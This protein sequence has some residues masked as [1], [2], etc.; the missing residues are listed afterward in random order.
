MCLK[1]TTKICLG[2]YM[3]YIKN[4]ISLKKYKK[5]EIEKKNH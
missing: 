2:N 1:I 5:E 4:H 3:Y